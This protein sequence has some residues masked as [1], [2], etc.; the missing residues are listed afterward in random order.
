MFSFVRLLSRIFKNVNKFH[1][2]WRENG[3][4]DST[5]Y[6]GH[7]LA[8]NFGDDSPD[9]LLS[10]CIWDESVLLRRKIVADPSALLAKD[11]FPDNQPLLLLQSSDLLMHQLNAHISDQYSHLLHTRCLKITEKVSFNKLRLHSEWPKIMLQFGEFM[12]T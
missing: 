10:K 5:L 3:C 7:R 4:L 9:Y 12:K 2:I 6:L 11:I 1:P 8:Y